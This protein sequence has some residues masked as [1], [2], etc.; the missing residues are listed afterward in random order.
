MNTVGTSLVSRNR[1]CPL[2]HKRL[3]AGYARLEGRVWLCKTS[4]AL[5]LITN[6]LAIV[7]NSS[8]QNSTQ[9]ILNCRLFQLEGLWP[10]LTKCC[11]LIS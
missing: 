5:L 1:P 11:L 7:T 10:F 3:G 6:R 8:Q 9:K 2:L 4:T